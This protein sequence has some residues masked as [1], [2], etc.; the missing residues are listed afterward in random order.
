[1]NEKL[2]LLINYYAPQPLQV[3]SLLISSFYG[4]VLFIVIG[5]AFL[6]INPKRTLSRFLIGIIAI[7]IGGQVVNYVK[8]EFRRPRP[9]KYFKHI[10]E[11]KQENLPLNIK[12]KFYRFKEEGKYPTEGFWVVGKVYRWNS[13][14][15]GH[16]Q[17]AF[18][19][20]VVFG[21]FVRKR[22]AWLG[23]LIFAT[24][25][26]LSRIVN[27]VH[28]PID[29]ATGGAIGAATG[30]IVLIITRFFYPPAFAPWPQKSSDKKFRIAISAGEASADLYAGK[31]AKKLEESFGDVEVYG[32]GSRNLAS[33]D[34]RIIA[35]CED[36]S[37]MG[38]T[39]LF[40]AFP[41][42]WK[43]QW[44]MR[45]E[46]ESNPPKLFIPIDLP[47]FNLALAKHH[48]R[49]GA[50]ILYFIPPQV[51][52]WRTGRVKKIA[53][54]TDAVCTVL[55]FEQ[56]FYEGKVASYFVGHPL[57]EETRQEL[58][59]DD[60][61]NALG[62][63]QR[64]Q[65]FALAP[66]SRRQE[67][68]YTLKPMLEASRMIAK[69]F[70]DLLFVIPLAPTL[71][72]NL[73][74]SYLDV[75]PELKGRVVIFKG[76]AKEVFWRAKFGLICSG[77]ATLEASLCGLPHLI[78]YRA[79]KINFAIAKRVAK[80]KWIGLSNLIAQK[81]VVPELIQEDATKEKMAESAL[82]YLRDKR[83]CDE[84][85]SELEKVAQ[86]IT[87]ENVYENVIN[88]AKELVKDVS[89]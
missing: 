20:A 35:R 1:M 52:A 51:W 12:L 29:I 80:V 21:M 71:D 76:R 67:I 62:R 87:T 8:L 79:G 59:D 16:A 54:R 15:S 24:L 42:I 66:G 32:I 74:Q 60:F 82:K 38:F 70:P 13:F 83:L 41:K 2:F 89:A 7:T 5:L 81:T 63:T 69:E 14:P 48:R 9:V 72:K 23:G 64:A 33:A 19:A 73:I 47:D 75:F 55:P 44:R 36:L 11:E 22:W 27:G 30:W 46:A 37:I 26:A 78:V 49:F 57:V 40:R 10:A 58:S 31:L 39:G 3:A 88:V 65:I 17:A 68:R 45:E 43:I 25:V 53:R 34:A 4:L 61:W 85:K 28:F 56:K 6:A 18:C 77:T 50:K 86:S 84:M